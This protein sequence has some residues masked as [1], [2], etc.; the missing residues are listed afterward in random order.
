[1]I[2]GYIGKLG[3]KTEMSFWRS[4]GQEA[5]KSRNRFHV[6]YWQ[7]SVARVIKYPNLCVLISGD[8]APIL[9]LRN[10]RAKATNIG[11]EG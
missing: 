1:M 8:M 2:A 7:E 5:E 11:F 10:V 4:A 9:L 6:K 3:A